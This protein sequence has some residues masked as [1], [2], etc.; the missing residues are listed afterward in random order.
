M[1]ASYVHIFKSLY[2]ISSISNKTKIVLTYE[3]VYPQVMTVLGPIFA[4]D[5][6]LGIDFFQLINVKQCIYPS[7]GWVI[8]G[9]KFTFYNEQGKYLKF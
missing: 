4:E 6:L 9:K 1:F 7:E 3:Y 8:W 2:K 5:G